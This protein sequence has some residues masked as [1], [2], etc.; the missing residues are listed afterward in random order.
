MVSFAHQVAAPGKYIA[1][2]ST[3]VETN[4]PVS[5]LQPGIAL[6]GKIIERYVCRYCIRWHHFNSKH[7]CSVYGTRF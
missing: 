6:L 1:I 4:D 7:A 3:T 2:A 5:E